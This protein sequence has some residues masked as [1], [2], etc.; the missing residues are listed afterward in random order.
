MKIKQT[1]LSFLVACAANALYA[2]NGSWT[3]TTG[4][5]WSE[6]LN[7]NAAA[8]AD[9]SGST[10]WFTNAA[11]AALTV[12]NDAARALFGITLG[13]NGFTLTGNTLT[14][15]SAGSVQ[16][17]AGNQELALPLAL[18]GNATFTAVTNQTLTVSGAV[19]GNGGLTLSGGRVV[20]TS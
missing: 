11:P 6:P 5:N 1:A 9:G 20:L 15:D 13:G 2:A 7:W 10:A 3:A 12:T 18:S 19:S 8:V 14:L 4:G 16:T 17:L